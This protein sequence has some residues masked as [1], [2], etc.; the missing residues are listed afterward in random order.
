M[1]TR[2]INGWGIIKLNSLLTKLRNRFQKRQNWA[3]QICLWN[4]IQLNPMSQKI[5]CWQN[6]KY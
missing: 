5:F 1:G 2:I 3:F 4:H 6:N